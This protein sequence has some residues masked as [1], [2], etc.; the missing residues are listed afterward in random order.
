V[1]SASAKVVASIESHKVCIYV[2]STNMERHL[3]ELAAWGMDAIPAEA[4]GEEKA[5]ENA[6][7]RREH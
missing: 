4:S 6:R 5:R 3:R 2:F 7:V 1:R